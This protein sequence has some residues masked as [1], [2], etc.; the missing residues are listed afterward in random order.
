MN[1]IV[2]K[3]PDVQQ[4]TVRRRIRQGDSV[5]IEI[6]PEM[7]AQRDWFMQQQAFMDDQN[8][9]VD[10]AYRD[11]IFRMQQQAAQRQATVKQYGQHFNFQGID[12]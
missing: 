5:R 1:D 8:R 9:S 3:T 12:R 10:T 4:V 6:K 11:Y 2:V 7:A